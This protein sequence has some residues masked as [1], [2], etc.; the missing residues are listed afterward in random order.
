MNQKEIKEILDELVEHYNTPEFITRDPIQFPRQFTGLQDIE[1]SAVLTS[2]LAWGKRSMVLRNADRLHTQMNYQP[3]YFIM[4]KEWQRFHDSR[5]N[6]HRTIF[7]E[8]I[9]KVCNGLYTFYSENNSLESLFTKD[10]LEGIDQLSRLFNCRHLVSP[11]SKSPCKRTNMMLRWLVRNDG[12]VDMGVWKKISPSRLIIPLDVHVSRI[13]RLIWPTLP[14]G[15]K[16]KTALLITH[17]LAE[18]CPEDPCKYDFA[19]FGFGEEVG[20]TF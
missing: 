15:D 19:L 2:I 11:Q 4:N 20:K 13:S 1:I 9:W 12:I 10:I 16:L 3:Y 18:L 8:E 6:I 17:Y 5:K 14:K 7:E